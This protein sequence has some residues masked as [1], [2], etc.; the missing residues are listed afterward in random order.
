MVGDR[1]G[2]VEHTRHEVEG[3]LVA[4]SSREGDA[5]LPIAIAKAAEESVRLEVAWRGGER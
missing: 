4:R 3:I 2:V 1:R 5:K